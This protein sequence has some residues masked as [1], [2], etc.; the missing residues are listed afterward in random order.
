MTTWIDARG[1][2]L[3]A[4]AGFLLGV[5]WMDLLFDAQ[6]LVGDGAD[7]LA[8]VAAYYRRATLEAEPLPWLI[9]LVMVAMV[10]ALAGEIRRAPRPRSRVVLRAAAAVGPIVFALGYIVPQA[11][12]LA[13]LGD[14]AHALA[15]A[16]SIAWT[17]VAAFVS[18]ACFLVLQLSAPQTPPMPTAPSDSHPGPQ[19][20]ANA[21]RNSGGDQP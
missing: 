5:L 10:A 7:A 8:S 15:T 12:S 3:T 1:R 21:Q 18:M 19:R 13:H 11:R 20:G 6:V 9:A 14:A 4:G 16:R 2:L 17:H